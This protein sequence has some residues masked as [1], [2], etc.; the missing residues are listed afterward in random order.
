LAA[1]VYEMA[2]VLIVRSTSTGRVTRYASIWMIV[3]R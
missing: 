3:S 2:L 1:R